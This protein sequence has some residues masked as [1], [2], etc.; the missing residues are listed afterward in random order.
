[1]GTHLNLAPFL[2]LL[3]N[4]YLAREPA[5]SGLGHLLGMLAERQRH[6]NIYEI[7][8]LQ[9]QVVSCENLYSLVSHDL[10]MKTL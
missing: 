3:G 2:S 6:Q 1:M 8:L 7:T 4:I 5:V 9:H 10:H